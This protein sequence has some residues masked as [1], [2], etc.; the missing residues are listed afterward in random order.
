MLVLRYAYSLY[1]VC[2]SC[3][4]T[5]RFEGASE[6]VLKYNRLGGAHC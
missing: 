2:A 3:A 6:D 1:D 4:F 5:A